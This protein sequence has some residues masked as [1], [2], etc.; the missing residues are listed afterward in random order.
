MSTDLTTQ[1][2]EAQPNPSCHVYFV[3]KFNWFDASPMATVSTLSTYNLAAIGQPTTLIIEGQP[4][5]DP[6]T[7][8]QETFGLT[9]PKKGKKKSTGAFYKK[10]F[11]Y[12]SQHKTAGKKVVVTRNTTF[13][14]Y[15]MMLK[16]MHGST[17]L[18]ESHGYH[19][20]A[21]VPGIPKRN[22][23]KWKHKHSGYRYMEHVFLN[24]CDGLICITKPQQQLYQ[25]DF[26]KIPSTVLVLALKSHR[27]DLNQN[28]LTKRFEARC[29]VY[30][31]RLTEHIDVTLMIEAMKDL[32]KAR[33]KMAWLGLKPG[34]IQKLRSKIKKMGAPDEAFELLEW[35]PHSK[36]TTY[37]SEK[38]CIGLATY[39]PTYRSAAV[40]CPTKIFDYY[41]VG[42]PVLGTDIP[43]V[44]D[45]LSPGAEGQLFKASDKEAFVAEVKNMLS[46]KE[47]YLKMHQAAIKAAGYYS[48]ENRAKRFVHFLED[49]FS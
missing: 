37:L 17:V 45:I 14:P 22:F 30:I 23:G 27:L 40:T 34:D 12:I 13:L 3:N 5:R 41:A 35:M 42:L 47:H 21:T 29:L 18:F 6:D 4:S 26:L 1:S 24:I 20:Q 9:P 36:M 7:V 44:A 10:A 25:A 46:D 16:A 28:L 15:L 49:I 39:R 33:I 38:A 43:T 2:V 8:L 32:S 11:R 19:G 48:W 31:G